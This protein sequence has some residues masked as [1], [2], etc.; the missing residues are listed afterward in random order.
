MLKIKNILK[1]S[2][3]TTMIAL[4]L[5]FCS[6]NGQITVNS[7]LEFQTLG[8]NNNQEI[9][10]NPGSY[11]LEDLDDGDR[12][13]EISGSNNIVNLTGVYITVPVGS[14]RTTYF[15]VSG[16]NNTIIGGEFEDVYRNGLTE[17]TD[18]SAYNQDRSNL[19]YGLRGAAVMDV[20]GN[21]NLVNGIKLTVRGSFPYGY[22]SMYGINA[23]NIFGLDKRCGLLITG[24]RNTIDN[25]EIQ[26]R[27]F[28][29]GLFMQG[30][31]DATVIK[32]TLVE[33]RVR[34]T[35]EL[36]EEDEAY[37]L[38]FLSDFKMPY[39]DFRELPTDEVHSLSEDGFRQY[40]GVGS[41]TI[42]NCTA[43]KMRGGIRLYLGGDATVTNST[44]VDCGSTNF[45]LPADGV[46]TN[47]SGN[48]AYAPLSDFRLGRSRAQI[49]WTV[50]PSPNT[51]GP[52]N[53]ADIE[54]NSHNIIFHRTP[55][56]VDTN[57][58][59]IVITGNN[60]TII[61]ETEYP[62]ILEATASGNTIISCGTITDNG[63]NNTTSQSGTCEGLDVVN[64]C[65]NHDAFIQIE[66]EDFCNQSGIEVVG[67]AV[68]FINNGDWVSYN[69]VDFNSGVDSIEM[70]VASGN[71]GG[72][73][74]VRE[75]STLGTLLGTVEVP[76]TG[77]FTTWKTVK[78]NVLETS[79]EKDIY[80]MFTGGSGALF[81][82]DWF[83][84]SSSILSISNPNE[85]TSF[86][87]PNPVISNVTIKNS[88]DSHI[89]IYDMNGGKVFSKM[90]SSDKE[91]LNLSVLAS[92][93]YYTEINKG[94][95][96]EV[97]KIIKD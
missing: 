80:L 46:I 83:T 77:S 75:G 73:I 26:Q 15:V 27:A 16:D 30:D 37:D 93:L 62:I 9:I 94:N 41:V 21:D 97:I 33:G 78:A 67:T 76:A 14:I 49:E 38:P 60:S 13:I 61:N 87:Y 69:N 40:T 56:P 53:L 48:F 58:R 22:G 84:F 44:A 35:G 45:N 47:S 88:I 43:K 51:T 81:D 5:S 34:S 24:A 90:I 64:E 25:V 29:H 57:P 70:S 54:G 65:D 68:G 36:Y 66:A 55:G 4:I 6:I 11:N 95:T 79:G 96:S 85:N 31:A 59:S 82:I 86:I 2:L 74:E 91:I 19:A 42:E 52:H 12:V 89:T 3:F 63:S 92:G 39:E 1:Q 18:F 28:G 10:M 7:L 20:T 72:T 32:N 8:V 50:I 71:S 17:V 23:T